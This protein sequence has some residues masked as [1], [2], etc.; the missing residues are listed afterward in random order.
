MEQLYNR[1]NTFAGVHIE[2]KDITFSWGIVTMFIEAEDADAL[3][4]IIGRQG[5]DQLCVFT[6]GEDEV[7]L[8]Q[9]I[10]L[11]TFEHQGKSPLENVDYYYAPNTMDTALILSAIHQQAIERHYL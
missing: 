11:D 10:A 7:A 3:K 4:I 5:N 8:E 2:N 6:H 1:L 9:F